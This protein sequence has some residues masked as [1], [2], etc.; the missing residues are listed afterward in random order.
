MAEREINRIE[1]N[2]IELMEKQKDTIKRNLG[3]KIDI[4]EIINRIHPVET[5]EELAQCGLVIEAD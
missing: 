4:D 1:R 2:G 3:K 5:Y